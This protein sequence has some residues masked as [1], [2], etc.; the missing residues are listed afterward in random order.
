MLAGWRFEASLL[1]SHIFLNNFGMPI[2]R[3]LAFARSIKDAWNFQR[4]ASSNMEDR[5]F[6]TVCPFRI[7]F[8]VLFEVVLR[9]TFDAIWC[10]LKRGRLDKDH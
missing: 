3:A 10:R 7:S 4:G 1:G 2:R 8:S 6:R 9:L 5:T